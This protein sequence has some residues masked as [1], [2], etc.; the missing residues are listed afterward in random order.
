MF[1]SLYPTG[2]YANRGLRERLPCPYTHCPHLSDFAVDHTPVTAKK[3]SKQDK[4]RAGL[5]PC[6]FEALSE[7]ITFL[8]IEI[9]EKIHHHD[10]RE[11][12]H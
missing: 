4:V 10:T 3:I 6:F 7:L 9:S 2:D 8:T 11:F 5:H 12:L 1:S